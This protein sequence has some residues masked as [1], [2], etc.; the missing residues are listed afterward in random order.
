MPLNVIPSVIFSCILYWIV[1][2]N[3]HTFGY[4][5]LIVLLEVITAIALGLAVSAFAPNTDAANGMA[6]P[7]MIIPLIFAG[8]YSKFI[9]A[10]GECNLICCFYSQF[11][12]LANRC[13]MGS[14]RLILTLDIPILNYQ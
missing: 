7:C 2:L 12:Q 14:I 10:L 13:Q 8:F 6:I 9:V 5:L 3:K 1:G 4:Y 11:E